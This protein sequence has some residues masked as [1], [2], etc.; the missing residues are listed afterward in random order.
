MSPPLGHLVCQRFVILLVVRQVQILSWGL[1]WRLL[2]D[3][4]MGLAEGYMAGEWEVCVCVCI[5]P[6][7][8]P[9]LC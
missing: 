6:S 3:A 8:R 5:R 2:E 1:V 7:P 4:D 9:D